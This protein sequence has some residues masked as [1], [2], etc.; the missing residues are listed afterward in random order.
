[1]TPAS[2]F[3][4][5]TLRK[6][7]GHPMHAALATHAQCIGEGFVCGDLYDLRDY[8][9]LFPSADT[10]SRISGEVYQFDPECE[11]KALRVLDDY[12]GCGPHDPQPREYV[13]KIV[14]CNLKEGSAIEVWAYVL[15]RRPEWA[16]LIP[17]GDYLAWKALKFSEAELV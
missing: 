9:G 3:V 13:R 2:I 7:F 4:Y 16:T 5:G 6:A 8:P 14:P 15:N 17:G 10:D 1:M 11:V 12:E